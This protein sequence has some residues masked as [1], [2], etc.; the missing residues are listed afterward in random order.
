MEKM[1]FSKYN[2]NLVLSWDKLNVKK[3]FYAKKP[4]KTKNFLKYIFQKFNAKF[5]L[6]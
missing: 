6:D 5:K 1:H 2:I 3:G 4:L